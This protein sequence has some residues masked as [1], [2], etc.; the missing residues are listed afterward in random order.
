MTY[1]TISYTENNR[2]K[3]I[4]QE[5]KVIPKQTITSFSIKV[6]PNK[7]EYIQNKEELNLEGG[8]LE[9]IYADN[10]REEILLPS[11]K[12]TVSG[13]DNLQ[14]GKITITLTYKDKNVQFE[15]M[16]K[17]PIP[18][19]SDFE[20]ISGKVNKIRKYQF[21]DENKQE[22]MIL[23]VVIN[24]I[25]K[26]I[27]N[28]MLVYNYYLSSKNNETEIANWIEIKEIQEAENEMS[29]EINTENISNYEQIKDSK[30][31]YLYIREIATIND[32]AR[33]CITSAIELNLENVSIEEFIDG[34]L[35]TDEMPE[36]EQPEEEKPGE[37]I[38]P[39]VEE[40]E[41]KDSIPAEK[42]DIT[43]VE[44]VIPK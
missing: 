35:K 31:L 23:N 1:V 14:V 44:G 42:E 29:F 20:N 13:F 15:V 24:D 18:E 32:I 10:T 34:Q 43:V 27:E 30:I 38:I 33:E 6:L 16:I 9:V 36:E 21:T 2:T 28:D 37:E 8:V 4:T 19:N 5:I 11:D 40:E 26:S 17:E 25:I 3:T 41:E 22:Y 7:L 39:P 12:I